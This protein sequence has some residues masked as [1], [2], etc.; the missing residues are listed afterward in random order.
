M[1]DKDMEEMTSA[2]EG[3]LNALASKFGKEDTLFILHLSVLIAGKCCGLN[4]DQI[5]KS[6]KLV[7]E[8]TVAINVNDLGK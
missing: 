7:M 2:M 5:L 6:Q 1:S 3:V 4:D 8:K